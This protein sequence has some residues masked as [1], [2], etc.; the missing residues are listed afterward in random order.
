[1][2]KEKPKTTLSKVVLV[3]LTGVAI[4][5]LGYFRNYIFLAINAQA[6]SVFYHDTTPA[7]SP[8][9]NF[10]CGKSYIYLIRLKWI[11][12]FLFFIAFCGSSIIIMLLFFKQIIYI[13]IC[14]LSY[15]LM[16]ITSLLMMAVGYI[17]PFFSVHAFNISRNIM[18][19]TQSPFTVLLLFMIALYQSKRPVYPSS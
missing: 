9:M 16:F 19:I 15:T 17:I 13:M 1:M 10:L 4:Y 8:F 5:F 12:T 3:I 11:L 14:I 6:S 2:N 18:H 7:L